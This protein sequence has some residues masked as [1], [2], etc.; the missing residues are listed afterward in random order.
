LGPWVDYGCS[1]DGVACDK[2][3]VRVD[4]LF[5]VPR[6]VIR[7]DMRWVVRGSYHGY[8]RVGVLVCLSAFELGRVFEVE[9]EGYGLGVSSEYIS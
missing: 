2:G 5:W 4:V 1:Q 6:R 7:A 3:A 8:G 9:V